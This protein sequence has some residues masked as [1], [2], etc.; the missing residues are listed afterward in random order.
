MKTDAEDSSETP[1]HVYH[2]L[3]NFIFTQSG[4]TLL[5]IGAGEYKS[6]DNK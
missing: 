1:E 3:K 2:S 4:D 5:L 6:H